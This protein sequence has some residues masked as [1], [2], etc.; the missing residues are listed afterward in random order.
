LSKVKLHSNNPT[1]Q[2]TS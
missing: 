1:S 2:L